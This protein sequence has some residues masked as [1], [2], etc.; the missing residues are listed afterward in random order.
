MKHDWQTALA[1]FIQEC[2]KRPFEWGEF[3]C[4]LFAADAVHLMTGHDYAA[5][6]RGHY[7]TKIGA[8]RALKNYG[9]GTIEATLEQQLGPYKTGIGYKRGDVCLVETD[10]GDAAGV[11]FGGAVWTTSEKGLT[12]LPATEIKKYWSIDQ[13][14]Q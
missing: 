13:C 3:D 10:L 8:A 11:F 7:T 1:K 6:F 2:R 12:A 4:C 5:D 9:A 14:H